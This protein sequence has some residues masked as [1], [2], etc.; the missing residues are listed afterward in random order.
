P[1]AFGGQQSAQET[2]PTFI[3]EQF[4][5]A[6]G[7]PAS[8]AFQRAWGAAL[9]LIVLIMLLNLVARLAARAFRVK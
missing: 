5:V 3:Y 9:T 7:N 8:P 1:F 2:L 4:Q 6:V